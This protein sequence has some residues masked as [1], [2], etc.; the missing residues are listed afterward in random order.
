MREFFMTLLELTTCDRVIKVNLVRL[1][2]VPYSPPR[3]AF[4]CHSAG[5]D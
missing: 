1:G 2:V 5:Y 3:I 4:R